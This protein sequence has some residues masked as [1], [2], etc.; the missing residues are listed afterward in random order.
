MF[1]LVQACKNFFQF[2][3]YS[4]FILPVTFTYCQYIGN[5]EGNIT[6]T[7]GLGRFATEKLQVID[8]GCE[9]AVGPAWVGWWWARGVQ[10]SRIRSWE[11]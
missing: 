9:H 6:W 5:N 10:E 11:E 4:L 2:I 8:D 3:S 7:G 1:L